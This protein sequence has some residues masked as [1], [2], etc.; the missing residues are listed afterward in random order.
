[1]DHRHRIPSEQCSP[2]PGGDQ[3]PDKRAD[4]R[5]LIKQRGQGTQYGD[6]GSDDDRYLTARMVKERFGGVSDMWLWRRLR[7]DAD[8]P[9]PLMIGA[10]RFWKLAELIAWERTCATRTP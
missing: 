4:G 2:H 6:P 9:P 10:R 3:C 1:M 8:F 7:H 5:E